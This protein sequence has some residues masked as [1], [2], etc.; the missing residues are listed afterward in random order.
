M[1]PPTQLVSLQMCFCILCWSHP[2]CTSVAVETLHLRSFCYHSAGL[3][4][5]CHQLPEP[6][7]SFSWLGPMLS[8]LG[9]GSG[10]FCSSCVLESSLIH[11]AEWINTLSY[12]VSKVFKQNDGG[13]EWMTD[14][15]FTSLATGNMSLGSRGPWGYYLWGTHGRSS[16]QT[17]WHSR[18]L[19]NKLD[20]TWRPG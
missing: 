5:P 2:Y 16:T 13:K 19:A 4:G 17:L 8:L 9:Q 6:C 7:A 14:L 1:A 3:H 12:A 18:G 10:L 15:T 11:A 20:C